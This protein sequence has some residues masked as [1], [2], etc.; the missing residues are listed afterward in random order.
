VRIVGIHIC[1]DKERILSENEDEKYFKWWERQWKNILCSISTP[2]TSL[3][4]DF[5]MSVSRVLSS[6]LIISKY[7]RLKFIE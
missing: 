5:I 4:M 3:F 6:I 1:G 2:L 7:S